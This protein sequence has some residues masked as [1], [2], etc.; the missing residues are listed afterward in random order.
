MA[1]G[2]P[3]PVEAPRWAEGSASGSA[4]RSV[5]GHETSERD[6]AMV[7]SSATPPAEKPVG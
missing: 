4:A 1:T 2:V 6:P 5:G 3:S 7:A